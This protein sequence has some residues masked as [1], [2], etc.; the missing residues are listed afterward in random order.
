MM[1]LKK[2][3]ITP[4]TNTLSTLSLESEHVDP[5][6]RR[7]SVYEAVFPDDPSPDQ[8]RRHTIVIQLMDVDDLIKLRDVISEYLAQ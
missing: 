2:A 5:E 1:S 8:S 4:S 3:W 6:W 7:L